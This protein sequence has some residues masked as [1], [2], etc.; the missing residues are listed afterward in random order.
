MNR[1]VV[2]NNVDDSKLASIALDSG[3][4]LGSSKLEVIENIKIIRAK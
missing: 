3:I 4:N 1:F 2:L